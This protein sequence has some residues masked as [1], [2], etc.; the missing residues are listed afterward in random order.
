MNAQALVI[1]ILG[2]GLDDVP[3]EKRL[4]CPAHPGDVHI[5]P[6]SDRLQYSQLLRMQVDDR[7]LWHCRAGRRLRTQVV[8]G[9]QEAMLA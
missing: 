9:R 3:H 5:L 6:P 2:K 4:A 8:A 1:N 7:L